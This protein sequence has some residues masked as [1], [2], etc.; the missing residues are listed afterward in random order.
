[1]VSCSQGTFIIV[2]MQI[3]LFLFCGSNIFPNYTFFHTFINDVQATLDLLP[4]LF[5]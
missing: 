4:I 1:M 2:L 3:S 5:P